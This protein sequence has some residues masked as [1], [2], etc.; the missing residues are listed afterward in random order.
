MRFK[1]IFVQQLVLL[2]PD[3]ELLVVRGID[4]KFFL[5]VYFFVL[6]D[7]GRVLDGDTVKLALVN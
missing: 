6:S 1:S 3:F 7:E 5:Y 2:L 4:F